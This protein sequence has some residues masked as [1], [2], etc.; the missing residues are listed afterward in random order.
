[1]LF[2]EIDFNVIKAHLTSFIYMDAEF[3]YKL[4]LTELRICKGV[5]FPSFLLTVVLQEYNKKCL[6][7]CVD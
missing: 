4:V 3:I 5:H 1:M 7:Y 2:Q 6:E